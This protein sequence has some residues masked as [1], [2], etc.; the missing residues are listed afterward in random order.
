MEPKSQ[1][2]SIG[3]SSPRKIGVWGTLARVCLG[4]ALLIAAYGRGIGLTDLAIGVVALPAAVALV[5]AFRGRD[6]PELRLFGTKGYAINFG[7]GLVLL[8]V[9]TVPAL[10]FYG[11]SMLLAAV[12]GYPGCEILAITNWL[13]KRDDRMACPVFSPIDAAEA[14]Q[15]RVSE[16]V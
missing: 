12:R 1:I 13:S 16:A 15:R 3:G 6:A 14:R 11:V 10:I 8:V 2:V 9:A 4:S 5:L 7:I